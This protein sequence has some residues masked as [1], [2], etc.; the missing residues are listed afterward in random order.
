MKPCRWSAEK[1][2]QLKFEQMLVAVY[3]GELLD[4]REHP[5]SREVS[6]TNGARR[7]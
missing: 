1:N 3:D 6:E 4:I 7:G 5:E 2:A